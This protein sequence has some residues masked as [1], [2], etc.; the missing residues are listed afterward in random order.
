MKNKNKRK[1]AWQLRSSPPLS[2]RSGRIDALSQSRRRFHVSSR[3]KEKQRVL[4]GTSGRQRQAC[5][6]GNEGSILGATS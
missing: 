6:T 4:T 2:S 1:P 3:G 5:L